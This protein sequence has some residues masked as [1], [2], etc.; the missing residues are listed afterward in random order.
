MPRNDAELRNFLK[1]LLKEQIYTFTMK[2]L[3]YLVLQS[4][5]A[6]MATKLQ[7]SIKPIENAQ[8]PEYFKNI[9]NELF[10]YAISKTGDF[11]EI[12]GVNTVDRLPFMLTSLPKLKEIVRYLNQIK[13][14]D[15]SVDVI[16]RVF[17][18]LIYE[19]RRHLLGQH[20]TDTK[21]VD[22]ILTGVFK[23]YGKPDKLLDPACGSGTFLVRA[24][25]Y[26]KIFYSTELD[27]LK[28]PIYEYVEGVDIDRLASM[29]AKI[30]LYIQALEKIK[31]GYKYVPKICHDDFFKINL[32]SD[33]AYVVA[34]PPYTKQV[35]MALAFY[36]KQY[37]ENLLNYV[38]DIENWDERASIYAY[39]L[40][41]G[42][43]LLRKNG[44]LGFIVENSWLNAEYGAP[45]KKWLF[46]NFSVEYVIES[47]VERWF[48]DAAVITNIIIA[49]MT[50]QSNYDVRFVF[51]KKSLRELIGD[52]PP[53]NDFMANMQYYKRIMELYYEFDNCTV[54]KNKELNICENEKHRVV[55]VKKDF[56]EKIETKIGRLGILRGPKL[57]LNLV[58]NFV[59]NNDNRLILLGEIIDIRRGLTTNADDIF[60]LPSKY[61]EYVKE[62]PTDLVV[63][64]TIQPR[65]TLTIS[66]KY[67]RRLITPRHI[68]NSTYEIESLPTLK[69][70]DYV[71][72]VDDVNNVT[73]Y[74]MREYLAWAENFVKE[75]YVTSNGRKFSTLYNKIV[76][77]NNWTKL[78]DTSGGLLIFR[79]G[80][81]KNYGVLLNRV[82]DAQFHQ[83]L[84]IGYIKDEF[85]GRVSPEVLFAVVNSVIT[86]I[87]MELIGQTSLG[88]GVL[89]IKTT[90]YERI[91]I[92][93]PIWLEKHLREN[94]K[95]SEFLDTVNNMLRLRPKD[96]E[97]EAERLE[98]LEMEKFVLGSLGFGENEIRDLYRELI[99]LVQFRTERARNVR[100]DYS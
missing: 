96:I 54:A 88:E 58:E 71:I 64:K 80:I 33:Y 48:E 46:K 82:V 7:E 70:E 79:K 30:N 86:Y 14:S 61:W 40:V 75:K 76:N 25:N 4:I 38:K 92:I 27:K 57:Y 95:F 22:L 13:W 6:D 52:P 10:N 49:E 15:I 32:S 55:T 85:R 81:H 59:N 41:R 44:R 39:F 19:E 73:D 69:K 51:L 29:L 11:E 17:E 26:W 8:D 94:N 28:M 90:D 24:L 31:E 45:L 50:A 83:R 37:K 43:K 18:G 97:N 87:G 67:L 5:D 99:K 21:I 1:L 66:K 68:E 47:L 72:W 93:N 89:D 23:K 2:L 3:F 91:P 98:R 65:T 63:R 36:D 20:Y 12:F 78:T 100:Q 16:G 42:G 60:Y 56:I 77:N 62:T 84:Y 34:N 53:A 35:E 74:G 9:A